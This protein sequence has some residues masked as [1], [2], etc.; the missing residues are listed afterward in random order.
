MEQDT[1]RK[2]NYSD[3]LSGDK[4]QRNLEMAI[5]GHITTS[6]EDMDLLLSHGITKEDF[7]YVH[8]SDGVSLTGV[9]LEF[10]VGYYRRHGALLTRDALTV[11]LA[12][13]GHKL[14]PGST[15]AR[16]VALLTKCQVMT[17]DV[18]KMPSLIQAL[19][20]RR[21]VDILIHSVKL[22]G[23]ESHRP[24]QVCETML[25]YLDENRHV[26]MRD[27]RG[28]TGSSAGE[29]RSIIGNQ[30]W[31]WNGWIPNGHVTL[32]FGKA[33]M[34]KTFL[35]QEI[36][37]AVI[38]SVDSMPDGTAP[39]AK[40]RVLWIPYEGVSILPGR[41]AE[42]GLPDDGIIILNEIA[43][44]GA[45]IPR[46][47][48]RGKKRTICDEIEACKRADDSIIL[49][50]IDSIS[51]GTDGVDENAKA[52]SEPMTA[53][54][55]LAERLNI[56]IL[57]LHHPRKTST[58]DDEVHRVN[59]DSIRGHSSI[60]GVPRSIIALDM[61]VDGRRRMRVVKNSLSPT[62]PD[63]LGYVIV[64]ARVVSSEA[65]IAPEIVTGR[66]SRTV[67]CE[68]W[69]IKVLSGGPRPMTEI[70]DLAEGKGYSRDVL[71]RASANIGVMKWKHEFQG[72]S[73]WELPT[74]SVGDDWDSS[75][76]SR[77]ELLS[78]C[79]EKPEDLG[80]QE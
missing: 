30:E 45:A 48:A 53:L 8:P 15:A 27:G 26:F 64:D 63:P 6:K 9:L 55:S 12:K 79:A 77:E 28:V 19:R 66:S 56:S 22:A 35:A 2:Q 3:M 39:G 16:M 23:S 52:I 10:A 65:P 75:D 18:D 17:L 21:C 1:P 47:S 14:E 67:E 61:P 44:N 43:D 42:T 38:G 36:A 24:G 41:L 11:E 74:S 33:G 37:L 59:M 49:V 80:V 5:L 25:S 76:E 62:T 69:L 58:D 54:C 50:V 29:L 70:Q 57:L 20:D 60:S 32:L 31:L 71:K 34:G 46:L 73:E 68:N 13:R 4:K 51:S 78:L 7:A 40:G 72:K